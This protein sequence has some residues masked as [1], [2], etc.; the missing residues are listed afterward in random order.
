[1]N[2]F[3]LILKLAII[4][5]AVIWTSYH[6]GTILLDWFGYNITIP[7]NVFVGLFLS[8]MVVLLALYNGYKSLFET[9]RQYK[10]RRAYAQLKEWHETLVRTLVN[11][12]FGEKTNTDKVV[13][14][15]KKEKLPDELGLYLLYQ[16]G[17]ANNEDE[18]LK[19]ILPQLLASQ[20]LRQLGLKYQVQ[21]A[22]SQGNYDLAFTLCEGV[23]EEKNTSPWLMKAVIFLAVK[24]KKY[25]F[26]LDH[27]RLGLSRKAFDTDYADY[28]AAVIWFQWAKSEGED[29]DNYVPYLEKAHNLNVRFIRAA[30]RLSVGL[31]AQGKADKAAKVLKET[32]AVRPEAYEI[33]YEYA[34][35]GATALERVHLVKE[36][37]E[38]HPDS[39]AAKIVLTLYYIKAELWGEAKQ[40]LDQLSDIKRAN[41]QEAVHYLQALLAQNEK[42]D[43]HKAYALLEDVFAEKLSKRWRCQYCGHT[44]TSWQPF[45]ENCDAFDHL[46][47]ENAQRKDTPIPL[48]PM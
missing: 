37:M 4:L 3:W 18:L 39:V 28:M 1:M 15:I 25:Q 26:A 22:V 46:D 40:A 12:E 21:T 31:K 5:F 24:L 2:Y 38:V 41:H 35:L 19:K 32:W 42:G 45:C 33:A 36:L 34:A 20:D 10:Q 11:L 29:N 16:Y 44:S 8:V 30:I 43:T 7:L 9:F 23:V 27:L 14:Q 17:N 13:Q 6:P 47:Y 48:L